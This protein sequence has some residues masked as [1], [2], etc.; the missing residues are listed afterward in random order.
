MVKVLLQLYMVQNLLELDLVV[1]LVVV[2][3]Q[4]LLLMLVVV[5]LESQL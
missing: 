4:T 2:R 5:L 1:Q 3:L